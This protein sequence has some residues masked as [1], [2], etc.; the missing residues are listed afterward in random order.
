MSKIISL[1]TIVMLFVVT[2]GTAQKNSLNA[3]KYVIIPEQFDF[4]KS[5]DDYQVNSLTKFLF[6]KAGFEAYLSN[7]IFPQELA[8]NACL[9]VRGIV[10]NESGMFATKMQIKVVDCYNNVLFI[11]EYATSREKEYKKSY[12]EAIRT[13]FEEIQNLNYSYK[14][15]IPLVKIEKKATP[16]VKEVVQKVD[17]IQD[18]EKKETVAKTTISN[19]QKKDQIKEVAIKNANF[20]IEGTYEVEKWGISTL[21]KTAEGYSLKAG[22]ENF[23]FAVLYK[24]TKSHLFIIKYA[25][26]KQ[27]QLVELSADGNLKVDTENSLKIYKRVF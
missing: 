11:T 23:E 26:Y 9:A 25:A 2:L 5:P 7:E 22:D 24:T 12:H 6:N 21:S 15:E 10:M 18:F 27:P 13:A 3:Y 4:Q 19:L 1:V 8:S 16:I 20:T 14:E 17:D